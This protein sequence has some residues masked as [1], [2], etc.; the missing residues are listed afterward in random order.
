[1]CSALVTAIDRCHVT[2]LKQQGGCSGTSGRYHSD[3][4]AGGEAAASPAGSPVKSNV[5]GFQPRPFIR[6]GAMAVEDVM[7]HVFTV[8]LCMSDMVS[9]LPARVDSPL[10]GSVWP[11]AVAPTR[12][13]PIAAALPS[14]CITCPSGS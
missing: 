6:V 10:A 2:T 9:C 14:P 12:L 8:G 5:Y 7:R 3:C 13:P 4:F 11:A 1:M